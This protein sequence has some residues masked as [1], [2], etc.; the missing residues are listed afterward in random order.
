[1]ENRA[2]NRRIAQIGLLG[3]DCVRAFREGLE[4]QAIDNSPEFT[5]GAAWREQLVRHLGEGVK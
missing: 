3:A 4:Q 5:M 2:E 1:M